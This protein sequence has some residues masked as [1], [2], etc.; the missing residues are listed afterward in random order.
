MSEEKDEIKD[1]F[2]SAF[3]DFEAEVDDKVWMNIEKEL[4]PES[5]RRFVWWRWAAAASIIGGISIFALL[6]LPADKEPMAE[7]KVVPAEIVKSQED[8]VMPQ[9][10]Q[11][12]TNEGD[13]FAQQE[14][15][16]KKP[17]EELAAVKGID[18][19]S[20]KDYGDTKD[21][22]YSGSSDRKSVV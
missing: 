14:G 11:A 22:E 19:A 2:S 5:K 3:E 18:G 10:Q 17:E 21:I 6:N 4:H 1:L 7:Q 13:Q 12:S 20:E 9:T 8:K 15:S 16:D